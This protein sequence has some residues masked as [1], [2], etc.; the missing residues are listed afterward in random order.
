VKRAIIKKNGI[1]YGL[2][3]VTTTTTPNVSSPGD[4]IKFLDYVA[5]VQ[6]EA[7]AL[8]AEGVNK[9]F[10]MSH[11]GTD[12]DMAMIPFLSGIDVVVG[13]HDHAL[14]GDPKAI[15]A[16][17]LPLQ[18]ERVVAPY[19]AVLKGKDGNIALL[20]SAFEK[21]RWLGNIEITFDSD[22]VIRPGAWLGNPIFVRGCDYHK[23]ETGAV[24]NDD[25]SKQVA[26]AD[27]A[28]QSII[29]EYRVPLDA[30]ANELLGEAAVNFTGRHA[31][32][33]KLHSMGNLTADIVLSNTQSDNVDVAILNRGGMRADL[34]KGPVRYSDINTVLPFDNTIVVLDV[35][36]EELLEAMDAAVSEAGGKS[37]GAFPHVSHNM[38]INY[39]K[40]DDCDNALMLGGRVTSIKINGNAI[41]NSKHYRIATNDYLAN[42]GDFYTVFKLAC[43]RETG[44]CN[45]T[46]TFLR[47]MVA[48]WFRNHSPVDTVSQHRVVA[49]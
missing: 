22:G 27:S 34:A 36:G 25:C 9:I 26:I 47:D 23:D 7:D 38:Q 17:G 11:S 41:E 29:E 28:M 21:G 16:M 33:A 40:T 39:C 20:V 14:F 6:K 45:D 8:A 4:N 46:G 10:L 2:L 30:V 18:A 48:E 42:G 19:P 5:S 24:V 35:T 37:Y 15:E 49:H 3:G 13:G 32:G 43:E 1:R 12:V 31:A 44:Y